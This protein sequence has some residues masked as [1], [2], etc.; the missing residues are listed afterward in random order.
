M[1]PK[2]RQPFSLVKR[3]Q[4]FGHAFAG[5]R[6]FMMAEHN[7]WLHLTATAGVLLLAFLVKV[8]VTE[9]VEL[10]IA[11]GLVWTAEMFNCVIEKLMDFIN[12]GL[13]PQIGFIKDVAAGS[14][15]VAS[16]IAL[17]IGLT[18]FIPKIG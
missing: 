5:I 7:G 15:L 3:V 18:I 9:A 2:Q 16:I 14:V 17:V 4:S 13:H 1:E 8:S 10:T 11:V 12:P 6:K